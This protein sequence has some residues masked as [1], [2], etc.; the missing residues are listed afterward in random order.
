MNE[1]IVS[2]RN[3][4]ADS[5]RGFLIRAMDYSTILNIH[6]IAHHDAIHVA[7]NDSIKPYAAFIAHDHI[8]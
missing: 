2:N 3:I 8:A 1:R 4:V 5:C 7:S 6:A